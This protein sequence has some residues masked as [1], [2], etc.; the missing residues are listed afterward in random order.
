MPDHVYDEHG[1]FDDAEDEPLFRGRNP[2]LVENHGYMFGME[3]A[4]EQRYRDRE[5]E[6]IED[7]LRRIWGQR[8]NEEPFDA[9][10]QDIIRG[11]GDGLLGP[12]PD[13]REVSLGGAQSLDNEAAWDVPIGLREEFPNQTE[14]YSIVDRELLEDVTGSAPMGDLGDTVRIVSSDEMEG[15]IDKYY[16]DQMDD[17]SDAPTVD[18]EGNRGED[19]AHLD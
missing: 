1:Y 4:N 18:G 5:W 15:K 2:D 9:H 11:W 12:D 8:Y 10:I 14:D 7:E 6:D 17:V 13:E 19:V 3:L 16:V